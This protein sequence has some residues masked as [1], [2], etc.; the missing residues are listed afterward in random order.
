MIRPREW[1]NP[2]IASSRS[3]R[4][5]FPRVKFNLPDALQVLEPFRGHRD[6]LLKSE[7]ALTKTI[8]QTVQKLYAKA[9]REPDAIKLLLL[10]LDAEGD[11]PAELA[12]K[13]LESARKIVPSDV[14][15]SCV[16]PKRMLENWIV[17][18]A[19]TLGGINNLPNPL[20]MRD[21]FEERSGAAWLD[22]QLRSV[23]KTRKYKKVVDAREFI[24][25]MDLN[26]CRTNSPSFDKLCRELEKRVPV[27][28]TPDES[29]ASA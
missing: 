8:G 25:S 12:P 21:Q 13:L 17:A 9:K 3:C 11:C 16:M 15:V 20:P 14:T 28:P 5:T 4:K 2:I 1:D 18:G 29:D 23:N 19:S 22:E 10:L 24:D 27:A 26:E 6:N 7:T